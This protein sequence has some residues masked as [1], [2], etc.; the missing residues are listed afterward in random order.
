[1][2]NNK[3]VVTIETVDEDGKKLKLLLRPF[4]HKV[5][6]EAQ[7]LYNIKLTSLIRL[8]TSKETQLFSRQQLEQHLIDLGIWTESDNRHFLQLQIELRSLGLELQNGGIKVSEAKKIALEMKT[9]RI[10]LLALYNNRAQ[11]DG[12]TME[13]MA[14]NEKFKFLLTKCIVFAENNQLFFTNIDDY[15]E[16]QN[17]QASIDAAT[18]LAGHFYGYDKQAEDNLIENKWL[19][20]F[21]FTDN[22]GRLV[23]EDGKLIDTD[24]NLINEDGRFVN[25]QG[26]LV[27]NEGRLV[28]EDGNFIVFTKPFIDDKTGKSLISKDKETKKKKKKKHKT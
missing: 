18:V 21:G 23:N 4:G 3:K 1:M 10:V 28:D 15:E 9:K 7:M 25:E 20:Q 11:F 16:R 13:S 2:D 14:D 24:G 19:R 6:Q 8:S 22:Q 26:D 27:D 5:L 17:E 12:M